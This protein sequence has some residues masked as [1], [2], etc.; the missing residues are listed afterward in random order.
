MTDKHS[1]SQ[2]TIFSFTATTNSGK[3]IF[4]DEFRGK[5]LLIV[6]VASKCGFTPQYHDLQGL[7]QKYRE[8][9][10]E[11]LAFPCNQFGGQ[12]PGSAQ[13]IADFCTT[14]FNV[15]FPLFEKIEVNG[16]NASPLFLWLQTQKKGVLGTAA[17]KWNFTKFLVDRE[18][19]VVKRFGSN[20]TPA[21]I[22]PEIAALL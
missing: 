14:R 1:T 12:E 16:P 8:R 9:G 3:E 10:L 18:G 15:E 6:N 7:Y 21:Q 19:K 2:Q 17:I 22:E 13:E 11:V 5:V 20:S 4:L